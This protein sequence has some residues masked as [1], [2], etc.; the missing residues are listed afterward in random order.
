MEEDEKELREWMNANIRGL[1]EDR[2]TASYALEFLKTSK[3]NAEMNHAEWLTGNL[4][5]KI[6]EIRKRIKDAVETLN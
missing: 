1:R 4:V 6:E 3:A 2:S 5:E